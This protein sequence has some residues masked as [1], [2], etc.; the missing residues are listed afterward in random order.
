MFFFQ[1]LLLFR[2]HHLRPRAVSILLI[3]YE[4]I[5]MFTNIEQELSDQLCLLLR[6]PF[7]GFPIEPLSIGSVVLDHGSFVSC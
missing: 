3:H 4:Y 5:E 2:L 7:F 1:F 6:L